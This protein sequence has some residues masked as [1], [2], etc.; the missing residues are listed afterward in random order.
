[1]TTEANLGRN[2]AAQQAGVG[3]KRW[4]VTSN[5]SR[6]P[7]LNGEST[8]IGETFSNGALWPGDPTLPLDERAG[9][10]CLLD[11]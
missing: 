11:F 3:T 2:E 1:V 10:S 6:H 4:V 9:C 7:H 5:K 8:P